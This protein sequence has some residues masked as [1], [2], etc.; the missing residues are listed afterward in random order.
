MLI[1][2]AEDRRIAGGFA[3]YQREMT[4]M[5]VASKA[6][7]HMIVIGARVVNDRSLD[8]PSCLPDGVDIVCAARLSLRMADD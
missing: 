2:G 4:H 1:A 6:S 8:D 3:G 5:K 7:M